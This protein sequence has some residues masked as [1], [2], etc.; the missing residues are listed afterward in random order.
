MAKA[1]FPRLK[2]GNAMVNCD[3]VIGLE[4]S[5][6]LL[7]YT[8]I[9][10][11]NSRVYEIAGAK[12]GREG[13]RVNCVAPDP[14]WTPLNPSDKPAEKIIQFGEQTPMKRLAQPE[15]AASAFVFFASPAD[16][17]YITS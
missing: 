8:A 1:A 11:G 15:E 3:S 13:I 2:S 9:K 4:G 16:S 5:K 10:G 14:V 12:P 17:S 6:E 7:D